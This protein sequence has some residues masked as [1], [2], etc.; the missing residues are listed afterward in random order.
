V[1]EFPASDESIA[2]VPCRPG[3]VVPTEAA[4]AICLA[5]NIG[6]L[7]GNSRNEFGG[8]KSFDLNLG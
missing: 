2:D 8:E 6:F 4:P 7:K 1:V 5:V 3:Y